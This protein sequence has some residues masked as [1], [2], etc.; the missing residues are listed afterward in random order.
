MLGAIDRIFQSDHSAP[1][2]GRSVGQGA[3]LSTALAIRIV[4]REVGQAVV[5]VVVAAV[6]VVVGTRVVVLGRVARAAGAA[7]VAVAPL[8]PGLCNKRGDCD[9][10]LRPVCLLQAVAE[11]M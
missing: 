1:A 9:P 7:V 8:R 5:V 6:V 4:V 2:G 10:L 11:L 3:Y